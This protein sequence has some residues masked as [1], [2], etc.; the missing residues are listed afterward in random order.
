MTG[1]TNPGEPY[2]KDGQWTWDG[3]VWRKQPLLFGFSELAGED[4][5]DTDLP[6][7]DSY[8][9]STVVPAGELLIVRQLAARYDGTSPNRIFVTPYLTPGTPILLIQHSPTSGVWYIERCFVVLEGNDSLRCF[10]DDA[11]AGDTLFFRYSGYTMS[12]VE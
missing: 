11:T 9:Q 4:L 10:V 5:S 6:A 3:S 1:I 8:L 12:I 7:G 2:F